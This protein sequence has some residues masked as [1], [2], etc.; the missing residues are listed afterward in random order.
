MTS[1]SSC[2]SVYDLPKCVIQKSY[3]RP[4]PGNTLMPWSYALM[5][6]VIHFALLGSRVAKWDKSQ[7]LSLGMAA[8]T[9]FFTGLTY[10]ST[11][12]S[13]ESIYVWLPV[14]LAGEVGAV[15]QVH[16]LLYQ[17]YGARILQTKY[18]RG[19]RILITRIWDYIRSL[20]RMSKSKTPENNGDDEEPATE[21]VEHIPFLQRSGEKLMAEIV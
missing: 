19:G 12:L 7:H 10:S 6:S 1:R 4:G 2:P 13:A 18:I 16:A 21:L 14:T 11:K 5:F 20:R 9:I 8:F 15:M 17:E 3:L